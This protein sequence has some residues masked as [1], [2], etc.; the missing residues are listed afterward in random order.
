MSSLLV[1]RCPQSGLMTQAWLPKEYW[2]GDR[3]TYELV[4]C[5]ACSKQHFICVAT[6]HVLSETDKRNTA[7]RLPVFPPKPAR[8][9][10]VAG[11]IDDISAPV[12][13]R[14]GTDL[15]EAC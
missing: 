8:H 2:S 3:E 6:G 14:S 1:Y 4:T 15:P 7:R 13:A 9:A 11:G 12:S 5:L 10:M